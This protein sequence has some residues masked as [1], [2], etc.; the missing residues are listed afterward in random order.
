MC[1][2]SEEVYPCLLLLFLAYLCPAVVPRHAAPQGSPFGGAE[3]A[4]PGRLGDVLIVRLNRVRPHHQLALPHAQAERL[5]VASLVAGPVSASRAVVLACSGRDGLSSADPAARHPFHAVVVVV[6]VRPAGGCRHLKPA[7]DGVLER[8][9]GNSCRHP[10]TRA[11]I[12]AVRRTVNP[13]IVIVVV[14][15][16]VGCSSV[17]VA[18][19]WWPHAE[20]RR[21][22]RAKRTGQVDRLAVRRARPAQHAPFRLCHFLPAP[23]CDTT[24]VRSVVGGG[25]GGVCTRGVNQ[26]GGKRKRKNL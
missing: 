18:A 8:A 20:E 7:H 6:T 15:S 25:G 11:S 22:H 1:L 14:V 4:S 10:V 17:V 5:E 9:C 13:L 21:R 3:L 16:M 2:H 19:G 24:I 12:R 23:V 26:G